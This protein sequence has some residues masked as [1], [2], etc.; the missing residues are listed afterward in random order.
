MIIVLI[1]VL[2]LCALYVFSTLCA[3]QQNSMDQFA[4]WKYTHRGL[5]GNGVP[6]NSLEAFRRACNRGYGAELD[7][8]LLADGNLA[9]IHDSDLM[10]MTGREGRIEELTTQCLDAYF[11]GNTMQTIPTLGQVLRVFDG[12]APLIVELKTTKGN[13]ADLCRKACEVLDG[14]HGLYCLESFD[15]RCIYWLRKNRPDIIRGQ[16][17]ENYFRSET[18]K[19]PWILKLL[20]TNLTF[21]FLTRPHFVAYKFRDRKN[22]S[23][24]LVRKLWKTPSVAWTLVNRREYDLAVKEGRIP[25]FEQFEP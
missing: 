6:E 18:S 9:V 7:V 10:R 12:Q 22:L 14:Y 2:L 15:P 21:N 11:L 17:A 5:H 24:T 16:L 25:I 1:V 8:H 13:Y 23:D 20:L 19:L 3:F 4:G